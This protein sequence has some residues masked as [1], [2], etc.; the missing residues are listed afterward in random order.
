LVVAA[1]LIYAVVAAAGGVSDAIQQL[2]QTD[3]IWL[4][5]ALGA[6]ALSYAFFGLQLRRLRGPES[7]LPWSLG[8][9]IALVAFGLGNLLP[10]SPAEGMMMSVS[11]LRSRGMT[12]RQASLLLVLAEW[13]SFWALVLVFAVDRL[14]VGAAGELTGQG[15]ASIVGGSLALVI[16]TAG[17]IALSRRRS[18]AERLALL[19]RWL[20]RRRTKSRIQLR[21]EAGAWHNDMQELLGPNRNRPVI[22]LVAAGGWIADAACLW[23]ALTAA[24][25][26]VGLEIVLLAYCV[27][28]V[29]A[30]LPLLPG[31]LGAVEIAL[32]AVLHRFGVPVVIGLA[33][34]LLWRAVSL[35]L[36]ALAGVGAVGILRLQRPV[37][38]TTG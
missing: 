10:A 23:M 18:A 31:G 29:V 11:E 26:H 32:P 28:T 15:I 5:P 9:L 1:L 13:T 27:A 2:Q 16:I 21:A 30:F 37:P 24:G 17:A 3:V 33:G 19:L 36:P 7:A 38:T 35:F 34:T 22:A 12:T 8:I 25:A 4:L 14:V 6:E 20:P